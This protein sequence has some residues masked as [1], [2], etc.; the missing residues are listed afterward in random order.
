M[1]EFV[2]IGDVLGAAQLLVESRE[3][4]KRDPGIYVVGKVK[5]D[6]KRDQKKPSENMLVNAVCGAALVGIGC[7]AAVFGY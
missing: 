7:H 4:A 1:G 3:V 6:V 5:A 2:G